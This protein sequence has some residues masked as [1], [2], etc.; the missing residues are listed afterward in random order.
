MERNYRVVGDC[1]LVP[2]DLRL[3]ER[4]DLGGPGGRIH[5]R[6]RSNPPR[7]LYQSATPE[8]RD[9][10]GRRVLAAA[11]GVDSTWQ[12]WRVG[13]W[14]AGCFG[15]GFL[16]FSP[17]PLSCSF[18]SQQ[19]AKNGGQSMCSSLF[20]L[21]WRAPTPSMA[22]GMGA[23]LSWAQRQMLGSVGKPVILLV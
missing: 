9:E 20:P 15:C 16:L 12:E 14:G 13:G 22:S 6:A 4:R 19:L 5:G 11:G 21:C 2:V 23:L 17:F 1:L 3:V 8:A 10:G 18:C 7:F